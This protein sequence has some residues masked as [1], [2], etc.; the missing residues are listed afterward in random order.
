MVHG[1]PQQSPA[2]MLFI[3]PV[4]G[5]IFPSAARA[6]RYRQSARSGSTMQVMGQSF[7]RRAAKL[8]SMAPAK[9][10]TPAWMNRWVGIRPPRSS[11]CWNSSQAMVV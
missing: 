6:L 9:L 1:S 2:I 8:P 10:P 3:S 7:P 5:W 11:S 4:T